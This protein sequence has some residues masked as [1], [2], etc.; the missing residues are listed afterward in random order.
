MSLA[1]RLK[2]CLYFSV[3][4]TY[5]GLKHEEQL[6]SICSQGQAIIETHHSKT[7]WATMAFCVHLFS[8]VQG[9]KSKSAR[10]NQL[11][12][13]KELL[14][15]SNSQQPC[16]IHL[17]CKAHVTFYLRF[18]E[19]NS[20]FFSLENGKFWNHLW[21]WVNQVFMMVCSDKSG[22]N[23]HFILCVTK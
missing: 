11:F 8:I 5:V 14:D 22:F 12:Y 3:L 19:E 15:F 6:F 1:D 18:T 7:S 10:I 17:V 21:V 2:L 13:E 23:F 4:V 20:H 9:W 16:W